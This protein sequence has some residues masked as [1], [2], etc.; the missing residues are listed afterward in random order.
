MQYAD[1]D[2]G[3]SHGGVPRYYR[4]ALRGLRRAVQAW[5]VKKV[6]FA[7]HLG[8]IVD[9]CAGPVNPGSEPEPKSGLLSNPPSVQQSRLSTPN[10]CTDCLA[11]DRPAIAQQCAPQCDKSCAW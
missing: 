3:F 11:S 10:G 1:I 7:M 5:R 8:D 6:E 2:D 9:G 4:G